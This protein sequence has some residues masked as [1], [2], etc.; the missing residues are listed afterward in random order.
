MKDNYLEN[1]RQLLVKCSEYFHL[2][3]EMYYLSTRLLVPYHE[4]LSAPFLRTDLASYVC[5][6]KPQV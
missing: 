3:Q 5:I 6:S 1:F 4:I 2:G